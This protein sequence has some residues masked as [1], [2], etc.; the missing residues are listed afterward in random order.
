MTAINLGALFRRADGGR[1]RPVTLT[2]TKTR[3]VEV[4]SDIAIAGFLAFELERLELRTKVEGALRKGERSWRYF[5]P[6]CPFLQ[7][8]RLSGVFEP[9]EGT[10]VLLLGI[11]TRNV[12]QIAKRAFLR[13][14]DVGEDMEHQFLRH[15]GEE[16]LRRDWMKPP[17]A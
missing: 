9:Y 13:F 3:S 4:L 2:Y 6:L 16:H 1:Q 12:A 10:A 17:C 7:K 5:C 11:F 8:I 15:G 14:V